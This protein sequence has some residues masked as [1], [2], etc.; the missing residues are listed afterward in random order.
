LWGSFTTKD[1]PKLLKAMGASLSLV[2]KKDSYKNAILKKY[3][4]NSSKQKIEKFIDKLFKEVE[5]KYEC[6][7]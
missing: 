7:V 1:Q 4:N 5:S 6:V 3:D 2:Q